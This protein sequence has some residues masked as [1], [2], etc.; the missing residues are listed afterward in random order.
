MSV[1]RTKV[2]T[3]VLTN[4]GGGEDAVELAKRDNSFVTQ[5]GAAEDIALVKSIQ[6]SINSNANEYFTFGKYEP[7]IQH[8]HKNLNAAL[9]EEPFEV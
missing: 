7:L 9:G 6:R 5:T 4:P 2:Y 3:Y 8:F 1:D